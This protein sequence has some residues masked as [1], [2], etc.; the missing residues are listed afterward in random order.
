MEV[1]ALLC[2]RACDLELGLELLYTGLQELV[3]GPV[4]GGV[5]RKA[6][7]LGIRGVHR[8][9]GPRVPRVDDLD[10]QSPAVVGAARQER[11]GGGGL[12]GVVELNPD[13]LARDLRAR[14]DDGLDGPEANAR[15][16]RV[17]LDL[18][19]ILL[20]LGRRVEEG[21]DGDT[22]AVTDLQLLTVRRPAALGPGPVAAPRP[23]AP[24]RRAPAAAARRRRAPQPPLLLHLGRSRRRGRRRFC[25]LDP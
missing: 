16:A 23:L 12:A 10:G 18:A 7:H 2:G 3:L 19:H 22:P 6:R 17:L 1:A 13:S 4:V 8:P 15:R 9:R 14:H 20:E 11:S 21:V 25:K 24:P 5:R